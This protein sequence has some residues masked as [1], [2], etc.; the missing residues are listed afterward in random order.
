MNEVQ[1]K[2]LIAVGAIVLAMLLYP[3]YQIHGFGLNSGAIIASGYALLFDLP[4]RATV[5]VSTLIAQWFGVLIVGGI[6]FALLKN[7]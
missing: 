6:A 5:D 1:R 4:T 2:V 3:P 7:K